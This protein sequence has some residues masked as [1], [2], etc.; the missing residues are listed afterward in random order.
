[1]SILG[2]AIMVGGQAEPVSPPWK[3]VNF[4]D[5]DGTLLYSY[6]ASEFQNLTALPANPSHKGLVAQGWNW[7]LT[8]AKT[9][10]SAMG[11]CIIG[12]LYDTDDHSLRI[13]IHLS[14]GRL[15]PYLGLSADSTTDATID[16]GD[17]SSLQT[18]TSLSSAS[19]KYTSHTYATAG[20]YVISVL[21]TSIGCHI[22]LTGSST[23]GSN[24]LRP[25][26]NTS[27]AESYNHAACYLNA[28]KKIEVGSR[29]LIK[30][31]GL[32]YCRS[33]ETV[34][35]HSEYDLSYGAM[36]LSC[37]ALKACVLPS[38][39]TSMNTYTFSGCYALQ[40]VS[41]PNGITALRDNTFANGYTYNDIAIPASVTTIEQKVL[42]NAYSLAS[43]VIPS[44][45]TSIAASAFNGCYGLGFIKFLS[46]SPPA[47]SNSNAWTNVP[48][49]CI[50]YVP[51]G[52]L[53]AYTT[54]TNYP[55]SSTYTYVEY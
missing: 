8:N 19:T 21:P 27:T 15:T 40:A 53:S 18:V 29:G 42:N 25:S 13:Y 48:S 33:I 36:F 3:D 31:Y 5:Y 38:Y 4:I 41:L 35:I 24:C 6:T 30:N 23:R 52:S 44:S 34:T 49:S 51:T 47:V 37:S 26:N 9:Q 17:D 28:I 16:W 39:N 1:M 2:N 32:S 55:S 11:K 12:Q 14:E 50:I 22:C 20:D 45:V 10:V 54:A 43:V 7:T 46:S